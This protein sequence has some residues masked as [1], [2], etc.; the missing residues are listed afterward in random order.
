MGFC[1]V[2]YMDILF[3]HNYIR[4]KRPYFNSST[5]NISFQIRINQ[6][7]RHV[8]SLCDNRFIDKNARLLSV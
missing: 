6:I 5:H 2:I 3:L 8:K 7:N 4:L 1:T